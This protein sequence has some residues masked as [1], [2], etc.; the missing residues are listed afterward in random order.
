MD[1]GKQGTVVVSDES[2]AVSV[3]TT[4]PSPPYLQNVDFVEFS[5]LLPS[6]TPHPPLSTL[7]RVL[8]TA[9]S[10]PTTN[11]VLAH[12]TS[13]LVAVKL[14]TQVVTCAYDYHAK[15]VTCVFPNLVLN[16]DLRATHLFDAAILQIRDF[17]PTGPSLFLQP[18]LAIG[19]E[20]LTPTSSPPSPSLSH[21]TL[22]GF[23]GPPKGVRFAADGELVV[24]FS[25][26]QVILW[27]TPR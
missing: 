24:G 22:N 23:A 10:S 8:P 5:H 6:A 9:T 13:I 15:K 26:N 25:E 14:Q 16:E 19:G 27:K 1:S 7:A 4:L 21:F 2:G 20:L 3:W 18:V 12:P 17:G 11:A